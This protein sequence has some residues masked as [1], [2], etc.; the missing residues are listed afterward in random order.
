[1]LGESSLP[2]QPQVTCLE[3]HDLGGQRLGVSESGQ[4]LVV[5]GLRVRT[6]VGLVAVQS[7]EATPM[8]AVGVLAYVGDDGRPLVVAPAPGLGF[9]DLVVVAVGSGSPTSTRMFELMFE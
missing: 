8:A 4:D 1:L 3:F 6:R 2:Q 5:A 7:E 9:G